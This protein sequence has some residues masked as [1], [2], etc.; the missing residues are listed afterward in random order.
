MADEDDRGEELA[1]VS[2]GLARDCRMADGET[3]PPGSPSPP[4][5]TGTSPP[6]DRDLGARQEGDLEELDGLVQSYTDGV[7]TPQTKAGREKI[8]EGCVVLRKLWLELEQQAGLFH[9]NHFPSLQ[10]CRAAAKLFAKPDDGLGDE[11]LQLGGHSVLG[12]LFRICGAPEEE[13]AVERNAEVR[14]YASN[15]I[16]RLAPSK[17]GI[18]W[19]TNDLSKVDAVSA[20][21]GHP[22][23]P[24]PVRE[25]AAAVLLS[26]SRIVDLQDQLTQPETIDSL[27]RTLTHDKNEDDFA[28]T[29]RRYAGTI[30]ADLSAVPS[31]HR[32]IAEDPGKI[33][34]AVIELLRGSDAVDAPVGKRTA[35][36]ILSN[37]SQDA[38]LQ[39]PI[40]QFGGLEPLYEACG[41][42]ILEPKDTKLQLLSLFTL[43]NIS[44]SE[45]VHSQILGEAPGSPPQTAGSRPG[46]AVSFDGDVMQSPPATASTPPLMRV[47]LPLMTEDVRPQ[48]QRQRYAMA[49][50]TRLGRSPHNQDRIGSH[51]SIL[52]RILIVMSRVEAEAAAARQAVSLLS[53]LSVNPRNQMRIARMRLPVALSSEDT[54]DDEHKRA[55]CYMLMTMLRSGVEANLS[56]CA[57]CTLT[58]VA[59]NV[60]AHSELFACTDMVQH[61]FELIQRHDTTLQRYACD[62]LSNLA[63]GSHRR[64][65]TRDNDAAQEAEMA[66]VSETGEDGGKAK[67]Y[68]VEFP[69]RAQCTAMC[70]LIPLD[71]EVDDD[72]TPDAE[73]TDVDRCVLAQISWLPSLRADR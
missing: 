48:T 8:A 10:L 13:G 38:E 55:A 68:K 33:I 62:A 63:L 40:V 46:T 51:A 56:R 1:L 29:L 47:I 9:G 27:I 28:H 35:A 14:H 52:R 32:H 72:E 3:T 69:S 21:F 43:A 49:I 18:E 59:A 19:V 31:L 41:E 26:F 24:G 50:L 20:L 64:P 36:S 2:R 5:A 39:M 4:P 57:A 73:N 16:Y 71:D 23:E 66:T 15:L 42:N 17:I 25:H 65:P 67:E 30:L 58:N 61:L 22:D 44:S 53:V 70:K 60:D 34:P 7:N 11:L 6:V 12:P 54:D 45:D 37:L